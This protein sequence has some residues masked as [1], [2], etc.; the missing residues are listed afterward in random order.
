M[1]RAFKLLIFDWDGTLIDSV[2]R[3]LHV[4]RESFEALGLPMPAENEI[5]KRIGLPLAESFHI[6][7]PGLPEA[8]TPEC[9]ETYRRFWLD[10]RIPPSPL[11]DGVAGL[12]QELADRDYQ[13]AI[14]TG[15]SREGLERELACH[16]LAHHFTHSRCALETAA[17]PDPEMLRQ[18]MRI[19][20][21]RP[22]ETVMIGDTCLDLDMA[23]NAGV[24]GI[25]VA[26]GGQQRTQLLES[27]P[28][29]CYDRVDQI[30]AIL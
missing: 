2:S 17:K 14:A 27:N 16:G 21:A 9:I 25:G 6:F 13:M 29:A 11:F 15:K 23:N 12:L 5:K 28:F 10:Q 3:I 8:R 24:A 1:T 18:L 20:D 26:S 7:S 22:N 30:R 4:Y 19:H